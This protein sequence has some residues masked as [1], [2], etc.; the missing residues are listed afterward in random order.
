MVWNINFIF[1]SIGNVI[2]P[3]DFHIFQ[4]GGPTT[5]QNLFG[6]PFFIG[7]VPW[8]RASAE[9]EI[10]GE[11]IK[12][13]IWDTAGQEAFRSITSRLPDALLKPTAIPTA[14]QKRHPENRSRNWVFEDVEY[15]YPK[16]RYG[17]DP[18]RRLE[19]LVASRLA[20]LMSAF[21]DIPPNML[22]NIIEYQHGNYMGIYCLVVQKLLVK[23]MFFSIFFPLVARPHRGEPTT[24]APPVSRW[25]L[26]DEMSG[27]GAWYIYHKKR[28]NRIE[29][30]YAWHMALHF[31]LCVLFSRHF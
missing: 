25:E 27:F 20:C 19:Q 16:T 31:L 24:A 30:S 8:F 9:V 22:E 13:Q 10:E 18:R 11:H 21:G 29:Y 5:N 12:L 15:F 7:R 14:K 1:P 23:K 26:G 4:R 3:I 17:E 2:I 6:I 28:K